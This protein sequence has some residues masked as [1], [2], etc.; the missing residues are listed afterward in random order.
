MYDRETES[1]WPQ[2]A[3]KA[4]SGPQAGA[5]LRWLPSED[6]TWRAWREAHADGKVLSP[7]NGEDVGDPYQ[8]YERSSETMFPVKWSRPQLPKKSW[9]IGVIVNDQPK[10]YAID[11]LKK[12]PRLQDN[13]A[14]AQIEIAYDPEKRSA[15][16]IDKQN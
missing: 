13:V 14:G 2:I 3:M 10:A 12:G 15:E 11:D 1:L 7:Q 16:I 9:V 8:S 4:A 5:A 6:M